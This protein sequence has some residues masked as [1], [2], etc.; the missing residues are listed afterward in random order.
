MDAAD[1]DLQIHRLGRGLATLGRELG[2]GKQ[3]RDAAW[4]WRWRFSKNEHRKIV[5]EYQQR[6]AAKRSN[7]RAAEAKRRREARAAE[8]VLGMPADYPP[9][10]RPPRS[11]E[12]PRV[13]PPASKRKLLPP[14]PPR[15][16]R[17]T[18]DKRPRD[19]LDVIEDSL[20]RIALLLT[21]AAQEV[22]KHAQYMRAAR[23][24][25][26]EAERE[27][28]ALDDERWR[29]YARLIAEVEA[30]ERGEA[31]HHEDAPGAGEEPDRQRF[32]GPSAPDE[33]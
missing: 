1:D 8:P 15:R 18:I 33:G 22:H 32:K 14:P 25:W 4:R 24:E 5:E 2:L 23:M 21:E 3:V 6:R 29:E 13:A 10:P 31:Q 19:P 20:F 9:V 16:S 26:E 17:A 12:P 27:Q 28:A 30:D 7:D 11:V